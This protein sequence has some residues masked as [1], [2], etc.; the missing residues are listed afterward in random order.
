MAA[1]LLL[2][3]TAEGPACAPPLILG[4]SLGTSTAL[5]DQLAPELSSAW[6][7][8]RWDLPGHGRSS[9]RLLAPGASVADLAGRVLDLADHL[10]LDRFS[11]AGVSLGGA[12]GLW[13]AARHPE[14]VERLAVV[15]CAA[16]FPDPAGWRERAALV[17]R[18]GTAPV[19]ASA[20]ERWFTAG[21]THPGLLADL[22]AAEPAAY[23]ACCDALATYDLREELP[24]IAAPTLVLVGRADPVTPPSHVRLLAD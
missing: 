13:L 15:S 24:T 12:V 5:W 11:Y 4:T 9:P 2:H 1:P 22:R 16:R 6:R 3:H 8:V 18:E 21:F 20:A 14:R 17:R 23:A 7:V 10:G 19:A